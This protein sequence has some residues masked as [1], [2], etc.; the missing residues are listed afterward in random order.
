MT[1][2][3]S[4]ATPGIDAAH[5]VPDVTVSVRQTFGIDSDMEVPAFSEAE[6]TD[7]RLDAALGVRSGAGPEV[8]AS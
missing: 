2:L 3:E 4:T 7:A 1:S 8:C 6:D 5:Q